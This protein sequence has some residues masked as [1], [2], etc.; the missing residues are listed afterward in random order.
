[1]MHAQPNV[2]AENAVIDTSA[3]TAISNKQQQ[4][5]NNNTFPH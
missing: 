4:V 5:D 3:N 2:Q 1:M